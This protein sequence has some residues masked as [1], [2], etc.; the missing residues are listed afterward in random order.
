MKKLLLC[1]F[2]ILLN[3]SPSQAQG[4]EA[5]QTGTVTLIPGRVNATPLQPEKN[6]VVVV[7]EEGNPGEVWRLLAD[8]VSKSKQK[9]YIITNSEDL[10]KA[11][12]NPTS[13]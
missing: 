10:R 5:K 11:V 1:L 9:A 8:F 12:E 3:Q 2:A 7:L 6:Y 13:R 4:L